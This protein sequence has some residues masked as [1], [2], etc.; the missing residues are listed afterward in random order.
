MKELI[1]IL[2][3]THAGHMVGHDQSDGG[4]YSE[5]LVKGFGEAVKIVKK[6]AEELN[7]QA[8]SRF[9]RGMMPKIM[10]NQV[11][12]FL[13]NYHKEV[14]EAGESGMQAYDEAGRELAKAFLAQFDDD[15]NPAPSIH[16]ALEYKTESGMTRRM[17]MPVD[18]VETEDDGT[19]SV[20]IADHESDTHPDDLAVNHFARAMKAK[21]RAAREKG[22]AGWS[23]PLQCSA[24]YLAEL[25]V[26]HLPK[27]NAGNFEDIANFAMMLHQRG[28]DP[29]C[30]AD[31]IRNHRVLKN[32][33]FLVERNK[34]GPLEG[35]LMM[36]M[37]WSNGKGFCDAK[38]TADQ[39]GQILAIAMKGQ[40][41][42]S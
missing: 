3:R 40:E 39:W 17:P 28:E 35:L 9:I 4:S 11:E 36:D 34:L 1:K 8:V 5:G 21:L 41:Q 18:R 20:F 22:R 7:E 16:L 37:Y 12:Q 19:V 15:F 29:K 2:D 31:A 24:E 33:D 25:L 14:F 38:I 26:D 6:H 13:V 10:R 32:E 42:K 27:G 30:L 23:D